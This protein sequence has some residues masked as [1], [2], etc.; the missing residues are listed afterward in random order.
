MELVNNDITLW[1]SAIAVST[2]V[3][4]QVSTLD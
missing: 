1:I 2:Q 3:K 4:T